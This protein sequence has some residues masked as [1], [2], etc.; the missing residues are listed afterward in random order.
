MNES[1]W[2]A[3]SD[4]SG[5]VFRPKWILTHDIYIRR[6]RKKK[7]IIKYQFTLSILL[8]KRFM[9]A[10]VLLFHLKVN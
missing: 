2:R 8:Y 4:I 3:E 6:N 5:N 7:I 9:E 10:F 1:E